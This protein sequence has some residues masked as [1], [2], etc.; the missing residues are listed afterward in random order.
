MKVGGLYFGVRL[1]YINDIGL[2][3]SLII[4]VKANYSLHFQ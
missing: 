2:L 4:A 1:V 3:Q